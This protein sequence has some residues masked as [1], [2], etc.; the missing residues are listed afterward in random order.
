MKAI[1]TTVALVAL[2]AGAASAMTSPEQLIDSVQ[3]RVDSFADVDV[4]TLSDAQIVALHFVLSGGDTEG[5]K[6]TAV[7]AILN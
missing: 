6:G 5:E 4:H 7:R 2:T 3:D 1:L